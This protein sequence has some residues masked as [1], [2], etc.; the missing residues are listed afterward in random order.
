MG[1]RE[2]RDCPR[3]GRYLGVM[4]SPASHEWLGLARR[5]VGSFAGMNG[6]ASAEEL[7]ILRKQLREEQ[8]RREDEQR[9]REQA[10]GRVLKEQ[11]HRKEEQ[12][13]HPIGRPRINFPNDLLYGV[14]L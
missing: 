5:L 4:A 9:R 12:L 1:D 11:E 8:S 3:D 14:K 10:E 2:S 6:Y 13:Q 7:Q